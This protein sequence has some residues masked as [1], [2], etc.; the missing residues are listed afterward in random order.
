M[1]ARISITRSV[2]PL[3][4]RSVRR[5]VGPSVRPSVR[6]SVGPSVGPS[7]TLSSKTRKINIFEQIN[8]QVGILGSLDDSLHL[9]KMVNLSV[10]RSVHQYFHQASVNIDENQRFSSKQ[11]VKKNLM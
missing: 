5:S 11:E 2:R 7:V 9:Y 4:R 8:A 6:R 1:R 3:D 10:G